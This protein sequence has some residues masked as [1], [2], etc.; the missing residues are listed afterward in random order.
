MTAG[1]NHGWI[2]P[3]LAVEAAREKAKIRELRKRLET[4]EDPEKITHITNSIDWLENRMEKDKAARE[5]RKKKKEEKAKNAPPA[6]A[7][8]VEVAAAEG[9]EE[10]KEEPA[11][12][13]ADK[14]EAPKPDQKPLQDLDQQRAPAP[15]NP[16]GNPQQKPMPMAELMRILETASKSVTDGGLQL[17]KAA[18]TLR[19]AQAMGGSTPAERDIISKVEEMAKKSSALKQE[20]DRLS[21]EIADY[22][23]GLSGASASSE[24]WTK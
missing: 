15:A 22:R 5:E 1:W 6:A 2:V 17:E 24:V 23:N 8:P 14:P 16:T 18:G 11:E 21:G 19:K 7:A 3:G 13:P 10:P 9:D 4:E 20:A 12:K